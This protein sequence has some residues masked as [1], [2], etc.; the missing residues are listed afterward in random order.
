MSLS[1]VLGMAVALGVYLFWRVHA[2]QL[3]SL[4]SVLALV[5]CPPFILAVATGS[6]PDSG[7]AVALTAGTIVFANACLYAG[8]AAGLYFLFTV[9]RKQGP[10]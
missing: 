10:S 7:L 2:G 8:V 1:F 5:T 9:I 3:P 6:N 4:F